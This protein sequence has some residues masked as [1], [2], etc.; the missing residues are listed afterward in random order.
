M[1]LKINPEQTKKSFY[2]L[3]CSHGDFKQIKCNTKS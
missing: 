3:M 1:V 2:S